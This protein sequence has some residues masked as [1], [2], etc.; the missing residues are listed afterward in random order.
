MKYLKLCNHTYNKMFQYHEKRLEAEKVQ[1][2]KQ[3]AW[4]EEQL[5]EKTNQLS[6][7]RKEKVKTPFILTVWKKCLHLG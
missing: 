2:E 7:V 5:T 1:L 3:V 6:N 4:F